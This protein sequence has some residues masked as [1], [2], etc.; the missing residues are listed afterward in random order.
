ML[1][2]FLAYFNALLAQFKFGF[3]LHSTLVAGR[4]ILLPPECS[5]GQKAY[6]RKAF[7][8]AIGHHQRNGFGRQNTHQ[9]L[10]S[11]SQPTGIQPCSLR[12]YAQKDEFAFPFCGEL[13][14]RF[15]LSN[16]HVRPFSFLVPVRFHLNI[17][18]QSC[19]KL[20]ISLIDSHGPCPARKV[21]RLAPPAV[22]IKFEPGG[23]V[24]ATSVSISERHVWISFGANSGVTDSACTKSNGGP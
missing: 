10:R 21:L 5:S 6:W 19:R 13:Q 14:G 11:I 17:L 12:T 18:A 1:W 15:E 9:S 2:K 8:K 23:R 22:R 24:S 7:H 20:H 4:V 3:F 16:L